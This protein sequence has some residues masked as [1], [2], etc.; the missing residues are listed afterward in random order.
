MNKIQITNIL[1]VS[2]AISL[3][4]EITGMAEMGADIQL[5]KLSCL[6]W[7]CS[8]K[9]GNLMEEVQTELDQ[10]EKAARSVTPELL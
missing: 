3:V 7:L 1:R 2:D 4:S 8:D 9:L 5:G 10:A 6:M